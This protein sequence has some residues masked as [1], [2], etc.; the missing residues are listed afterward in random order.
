MNLSTTQKAIIAL[1]ISNTIWGIGSPIYKWVLFD[2]HPFTLAL[3][4]F[5]IPTLI[6][7][8]FVYKELKIARKDWKMLFLTGFLGI[9]VNISFFFLGLTKTQSINAPIIAS[10]A[11]IFVIIGSMLLFKE[12]VKKK[13]IVGT[14]I[15]FTGIILIILEP[16]LLKGLDGSVSGNIL[17]FVS[18]L[19][20]TGSVLFGHKISQKYSP[21]VI[22]FYSFLIGSVCFLPFAAGEAAK[23]GF[24]EQLTPRAIGGVLFGIFF[25]SLSA[26]FLFYW[27]LKKISASEAGLFTY[28]DP[29]T[30]IVIAIPLLGEKPTPLYLLGALLVFGGIYIAERRINYHPMH[31]LKRVRPMPPR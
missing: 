25:S 26:Y 16:L 6:L 3:L 10:A 22:A 24:V 29:I 28:L 4:R 23:Y 27:G 31:L 12:K 17:L 18:M 1:C 5:Y 13:T 15:G 20:A 11:P 21:S 9:G 30:A 2:I 14:L 7:L 8:P 19:G